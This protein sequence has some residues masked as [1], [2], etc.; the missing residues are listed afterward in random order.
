MIL[1]NI[2]MLFSLLF[3]LL[4]GCN[5]A[6]NRQPLS[7]VSSNDTLKQRPIKE[8]NNDTII[9]S[10]HHL[11]RQT[12]KVCDTV[13][14]ADN[15]LSLL[16][17]NIAVFSSDTII[18]NQLKEQVYYQAFLQ[19]THFLEFEESSFYKGNFTFTFEEG[20]I[21]NYGKCFVGKFYFSAAINAAQRRATVIINT[22]RKEISIWNFDD[23]NIRKNIAEC[24]FNVRGKH[25]IYRIGYADK[26]KS[27]ILLR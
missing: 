12:H 2:D 26:C 5:T 20:F 4:C 23:I 19:K 15:E 11:I 10:N 7:V 13:K 6:N 24:D 18:E 14:S 1:K 25:T 3:C 27:F 17:D 8:G 9:V 16:N 22:E 21:K